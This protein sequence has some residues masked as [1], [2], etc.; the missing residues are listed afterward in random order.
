VTTRYDQ[1]RWPAVTTH[2]TVITKRQACSDTCQA[3]THSLRSPMP[4]CQRGTGTTPIPTIHRSHGGQNTPEPEPVKHTL[5]L[6]L[7]NEIVEHVRYVHGVL[8]TKSSLKIVTKCISS[9]PDPV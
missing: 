6:N 2:A 3:V 7:N 8:A 5:N 9:N 1:L 4:P